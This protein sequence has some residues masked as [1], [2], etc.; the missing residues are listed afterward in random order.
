MV[1]AG[2][3]CLYYRTEPGCGAAIDFNF[4]LSVPFLE[5]QDVVL[6]GVFDPFLFATPG[7]FHGAHF[8]SPPGRS[9][10]VH[11]K[12]QAPT[13]AFDKT[14]FAGVGQD[15]SSADENRY[16]LTATGM[17]WAMEVGDEWL[18]PREKV[19]IT[20]AY[21]GFTKFALSNGATNRDWYLKENAVLELVFTE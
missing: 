20:K 19:E 18:Y 5:P 17:P 4:K 2:P 9:Y 3:D 21:P 13:E 14:L 15:R 11:L 6:T 16:F 1:A 12:N 10:E 7:E 8:V